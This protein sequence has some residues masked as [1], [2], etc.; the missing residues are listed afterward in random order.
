MGA[1]TSNEDPGKDKSGSRTRAVTAR[2]DAHQPSHDVAL[3]SASV[4]AQSASAQ[5]NDRK[6]V[7]RKDLAW[8]GGASSDERPT[9]IGVSISA[10]SESVGGL[11]IAEG[12][13]AT[14]IG[15]C[16]GC[17]RGAPCVASG[18]VASPMVHLDGSHTAAVATGPWGCGTA[19]APGMPPFPG[20]TPPQLAT[21]S[22]MAP[23]L[24]APPMVPTLTVPNNGALAGLPGVA[25]GPTLGPLGGPPM[26]ATSTTSLLSQPTPQS[27]AKPAASQAD[28]QKRLAQIQEMSKQV[29]ATEA[30]LRQ[31]RMSAS[32]AA[33]VVHGS[34]PL[35]LGSIPE[36]GTDIA[37][38]AQEAPLPAQALAAADQARQ[39][40]ASV[41]PEIEA[42]QE[43]LGKVLRVAKKLNT[44]FVENAEKMNIQDPS[45]TP[46]AFLERVLE[47]CESRAEAL[48][49]AVARAV[50]SATSLENQSASSSPP[51]HAAVMQQPAVSVL[52]S[53]PLS[54]SPYP[55][56][57][58][59][60]GVCQQ[61][62][63]SSYVPPPND[64]GIAGLWVRD[65]DAVGTQPAA[66]AVI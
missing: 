63:H 8:L 40:G 26:G 32:S 23:S 2:P 12:P 54:S 30:E 52:P 31:L 27:G 1:A 14:L 34:P 60:P 11:P 55:A 62:G 25:A 46:S 4:S 47:E 56:L 3:A 24:G 53:Q 64:F 18:D 44:W 43:K 28:V 35:A 36:P 38:T 50:T 66:E 21:P 16:L 37:T 41:R 61:V 51:T 45:A 13:P 10:T 48:N 22:L 19:P 33:G 15:Q 7:G 65:P 49:S 20:L 42:V 17:G 9:D 59:V 6:D 58:G 29:E 5:P 39:L 57:H